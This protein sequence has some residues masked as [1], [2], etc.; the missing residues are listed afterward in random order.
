[1]EYKI[2]DYVFHAD[3]KYK[4]NI[5]QAEDNGE[6]FAVNIKI[7]FGNKI[8]P[9]AVEI[10][11]TTQTY[12]AY[13][14]WSPVSGMNREIYPEWW[15][16]ESKSRSASG[17]PIQCY[18]G[19]D[20]KNRVT[21]YTSDCKTPMSIKTG[22][23]EETGEI[24]W[25]LKLF[26]ER[27]GEI[28][29][30]S[31][32]VFVDTRRISY[33][34]TIAEAC[35][36]W[37]KNE[38]CEKPHSAFD[39][40]YST[41]YSY[42]QNFNEEKLLDELKKAAALGMKTVIIDDG[43]Q[44]EDNGRGYMYCGDWKECASKIPDMGLFADK[45]H[46]LGMKL[47]VWFSVPFM[48]DRAEIKDLFHDKTLYYK[49]DQG[50]GILDPRY[51]EVRTYLSELYERAVSDWRLD[52]LKL[53]FIDSFG[54]LPESSSFNDDMDMDSLEDAICTLV[55]D[56]YER[57]IRIKPD[58]LIEF[59]QTYIGPIMKK[60]GNMLRAGDCPMAAVENRVSTI[61]L[62]LTSAPAAVHSDMLLWN[63][64]DT[65]E[66]A[67]EQIINVLFSVPQI[68]MR[69]GELS[70]EHYNMLKF[71]LDFWQRNQETLMF[72]KL[73]ACSPSANYSMVKSETDIE[74]VAVAYSD[75]TLR[76]EKC[77][78]KISFV[79][80]TGTAGLYID[81]N[82]A[83]HAYQ[84]RI[85]DCMGNSLDEGN[86]QLCNEVRRFDVPKSGM[87]ELKNITF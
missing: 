74:M 59:R 81:G 2:A 85:F 9:E 36:E 62:R 87:V 24:K 6:V 73:T 19:S 54:L 28:Q 86:L 57:L 66:E 63:Y 46:A 22:V 64:T 61:D 39:M 76:L 72:G 20:D 33:M 58:I 82:I 55:S 60:Y 83:S 49:D 35:S 12:G 8:T 38:I 47:M 56:I 40:L 78:D 65:P 79:N 14:P 77:Y 37:D 69:I 50:A 45:V 42:H 44:T 18:I 48:G 29:S 15:M 67:A 34:Q 71:Y 30:Y 27:V 21:V 32:T 26:S 5:E 23:I 25:V 70:E 52:G 75:K 4:V 10:W 13:V 16:S 68:S 3:E 80:G 17:I 7:D 43:W 51:P 31:V 41:W 84:Y 53:D 11:W 1:M